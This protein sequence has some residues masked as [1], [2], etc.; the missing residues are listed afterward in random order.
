[1]PLSKAQLSKKGGIMASMYSLNAKDSGMTLSLSMEI[2]QK[3]QA[4]VEDT[5]LKN[6]KYKVGG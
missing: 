5:L 4:L 1:M 3:L 2:N 6:M